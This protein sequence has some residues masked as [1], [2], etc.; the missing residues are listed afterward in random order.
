MQS[1]TMYTESRVN[2]MLIKFTLLWI[3]VHFPLIQTQFI[4]QKGEII[5]NRFPRRIIN[6]LSKFPWI[7]SN[8][9]FWLAQ[10]KSQAGPCALLPPLALRN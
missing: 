9:N 10:Q 5:S 1:E 7:L 6:V 2:F 8:I 4:F 3:Y